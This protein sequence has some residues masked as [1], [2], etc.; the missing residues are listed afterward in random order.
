MFRDI[1]L[2]RQ[3]RDEDD[4]RQLLKE[5]V[6]KIAFDYKDGFTVTLDITLLFGYKCQL[7]LK[8]RRIQGCLHLEFH[9][10]PYTHWL[11][12]FQEEPLLDFDIRAYLST[13]ESPQLANIIG[14]VIRRV[15]RRKH[16]WPRYKIRY[17][18]FF[19]KSKSTISTEV[20]SSTDENLIPG[21]FKIKIKYCD[22]LTI[23]YEIFNRTE[24]SSLAIF[25]TMNIHEQRCDEYFQMY[26]HQWR[27]EQILFSS[28]FYKFNV[29]E[30][31][32]MN[33][34]EFLINEFDPIPDEIDDKQAF[35][36]ALEERNIF[37]LEIQGERVETLK[38]INQLIHQNQGQIEICIG[39]PLLYS[40]EVRRRKTDEIDQSHEHENSTIIKK[41]KT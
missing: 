28:K 38:K 22:R 5:V 34:T 25:L 2:E 27:E 35:Q 12:V 26:R 37:L 23:P 19:S 6:T 20:L 16:I 14:Q 17:P 31:K 1:Q 40:V 32:Y 29:K 33:R 8:V 11:A 30:V 41:V 7:F 24:Y 4:N 39:M 21:I 9:R 13:R 15:I 3:E 36:I 18:P 10:E